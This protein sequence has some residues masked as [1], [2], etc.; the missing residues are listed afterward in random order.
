MCGVLGALAATAGV[1]QFNL[2]MQADNPAVL[3]LV[4]RLYPDAK[5]SFSQG[6]CEA[7]VP[8]GS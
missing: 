8:I 7:V 1:R 5:L 4:R 6:T 3:R 2:N